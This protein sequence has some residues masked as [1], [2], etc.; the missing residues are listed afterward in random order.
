MLRRQ[1]FSDQRKRKVII[2]CC[3]TPH[4]LEWEAVIIECGE[5][6]M[7]KA[8]RAIYMVAIDFDGLRYHVIANGTRGIIGGDRRVGSMI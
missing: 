2:A 8:S 6:V 7:T 3:I 4:T 5:N 1:E